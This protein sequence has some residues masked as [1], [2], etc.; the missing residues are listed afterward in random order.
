MTYDSTNPDETYFQ[1]QTRNFI[2]GDRLKINCT[3]ILRVN[4]FK[5]SF[6]Y[7]SHLQWNMLSLELRMIDKPETFKLRLEQHLWLVAESNLGT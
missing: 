1:R 4:A 5:N 6:F 7:R 3:I 2:D